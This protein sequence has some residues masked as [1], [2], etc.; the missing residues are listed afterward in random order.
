MALHHKRLR[1]R[2]RRLAFDCSPAEDLLRPR[3]NRLV[4]KELTNRNVK[5]RL[6]VILLLGIVR[7]LLRFFRGSLAQAPLPL[8]LLTKPKRLVSQNTGQVIVKPPRL[9]R[10]VAIAS[11]DINECNQRLGNRSNFSTENRL[12]VAIRF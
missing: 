2:L 3:R 8:R 5:K 6:T 9:L 11:E 12:Q 1:H 10:I 7:R 4:V